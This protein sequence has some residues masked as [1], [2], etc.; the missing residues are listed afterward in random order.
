MAP[1]RRPS[2][3]SSAPRRS[4]RSSP[5]SSARTS[6]P[7][8]SRPRTPRTCPTS[9]PR[10]RPASTSCSRSRWPSRSR[11][12]RA[13]NEACEAAGVKLS[14]AKI[15]RW[16]EAV[17]VGHDLVADGAAGD[18]VALHVHRLFPGYPNTGW[19]LDPARGRGVARLGQPRL[20]H[21]ALV[22]RPRADPRRRPVRLAPDGHAGPDRDGHLRV[23][24][25]ASR[26]PVHVVRDPGPGGHGTRPLHGHRHGGGRRHP[27]LRRR[28][29]P[30]RRRARPGL[31]RRPVHRR[32]HD[33]GRARA[34]LPARLRGAGRGSRRGDR[35]RTVRRRSTATTGWPPWPW[36]RARSARGARTSSSGCSAGQAAAR[37]ADRPAARPWTRPRTRPP[38]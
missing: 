24:G 4:R 20:R 25:S 8:S 26:Q 1:A 31:P 29:P 16:L 6:T 27:R 34:V 23:P 3:R 17:K 14:L 11:N 37:A 12:A 33:L 38:M 30:P 21:R 2:R 28:R 15:S 32:E 9:S 18:L 22:R 5:C 19:P 36:R 13:M 35:G 7:W 10:P